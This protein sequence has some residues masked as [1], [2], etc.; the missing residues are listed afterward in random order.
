ML[1]ELALLIRQGCRPL[2]APIRY[3]GEEFAVL[4]RDI[5]EEPAMPTAGRIREG[6]AAFDW[7]RIAAGLAVTVS[8]GV[9]FGAD[10][11]SSTTVMEY[12][13][14]RLYEAKNAARNRVIGRATI[15][16]GP[17]ASSGRCGS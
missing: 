3:D 15:I 10:A 13:D 1:Q 9:A 6:I 4:L 7:T 14:R 8:I 11:D 17:S 12:A 2:D 16:E 5:D